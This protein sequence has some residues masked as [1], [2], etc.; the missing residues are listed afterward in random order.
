MWQH[1]PRG[2]Y[3][4]CAVPRHSGCLGRLSCW[5][6]CV[7][8]EDTLWTQRNAG[9]WMRET[10]VPLDVYCA[11]KSKLRIMIIVGRIIS[12]IEYW[13]RTFNLLKNFVSAASKRRRIEELIYC[14]NYLILL[15]CLSQVLRTSRAVFLNRRAAARYRALASIIPG[16]E[17]FFWNLSF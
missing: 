2:R 7:N 6:G 3:V 17:R 9:W 11:A 8:L 12:K 15:M 13:M 14:C 4:G 1:N 16:R 5:K 10:D